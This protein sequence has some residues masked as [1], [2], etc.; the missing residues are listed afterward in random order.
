M[1][2]FNRWFAAP[3]IFGTLVVFSGCFAQTAP[4][5]GDENAES[6]ENV[7]EVQSAFIG[8]SCSVRVPGSCTGTPAGTCCGA[9]GTCRD[10]SNDLNNCGTC[11]HVCPT[12]CS[13]GFHAVCAAGNCG[14]IP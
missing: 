1:N 3:V 5:P 14:C 8:Q 11:G 4:T 12:N 9:P 7:G 13:G 6:N 2:K 10:L